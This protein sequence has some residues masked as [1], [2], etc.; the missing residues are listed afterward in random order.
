HLGTAVEKLTI[1]DGVVSVIG[2]PQRKISYGDLLGGKQFNV[3]ITA[4]GIQGAM[5]V[6][7]EV[8]AK[9]YKSYKVVGQSML[10]VDLPAKLTG[11]FKFNTDVHV[12]CM[13]HGRVVR[14]MTAISQAPVVD[15][16]SIRHIPGIVKV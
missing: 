3:R 5:V 10:R 9:N 14:P 6:A 1:T 11:E 16:N 2:E 7:P 13:L 15:E 12:P 4:S 8:H